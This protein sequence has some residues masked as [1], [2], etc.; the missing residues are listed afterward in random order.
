[1][2][3]INITWFRVFYN[4]YR[5]N[6]SFNG[7]KNQVREHYTIETNNADLKKLM[8]EFKKY[9]K[10]WQGNGYIEITSIT[11]GPFCEAQEWAEKHNSKFAGKRINFNN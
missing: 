3:K 1:M 4:Y 11:A 5:D 9:E 10:G 2:K 7:E 8:S 6:G